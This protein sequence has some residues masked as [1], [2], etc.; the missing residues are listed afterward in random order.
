M[1]RRDFLKGLGLAAIAPTALE[2][3]KKHRKECAEK[4]IA[5]AI[6]EKELPDPVDGIWMVPK[7]KFPSNPVI[8]ALFYNQDNEILYVYD[9]R[10]WI[11]VR[12]A[13]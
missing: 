13:V 4:R 6:L 11:E 12:S 1:D 7:N 5:K 9:G 10:S 2:F 3:F 8:G